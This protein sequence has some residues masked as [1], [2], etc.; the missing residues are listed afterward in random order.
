MG[1]VFKVGTFFYGQYKD[2]HG[3]H[4]KRSTKRTGEKSARLVMEAWEKEA[5]HPELARV[6]LREFLEDRLAK[7]EPTVERGT[8]TRYG[9]ALQKLMAEGSPL[10]ELDVA[11]VEARHLS[12]YVTHRLRQGVSK[13]TALKEIVWLKG[14]LREARRQKLLSADA[15]A[16]ILEIGP[17]HL[18]ALRGASASRERVLY[19]EERELLFREAGTNGNLLDALTLAFY[20]GLRQENILTLREGQVDFTSTPSVIRYSPEEMKNKRGHLVRLCEGAREVLWRR[21]SM[22]PSTPERLLFSDFRS[23][24]KRLNAR[25]RRERKLQGFRFHDFRR[26]YVT[27][28]LAANIDFKTVQREVAHETSSMTT[29]C[30]GVALEDPKVR[31]WAQKHFSWTA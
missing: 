16:D 8:W 15:L 3:K 30:Y 18:A 22:D 10:R 31:E 7:Q 27:Y 12:D 20:T 9:F 23:A 28:R 29:D 2:R 14:Q 21:H 26:T 1:T 6:R 19:P 17:R 13:P 24:W 25:L 5:K 4:V 11:D